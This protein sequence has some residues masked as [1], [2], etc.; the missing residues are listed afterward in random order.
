MAWSIGCVSP[1]VCGAVVAMLLAG[2]ENKA[3]EG[4][5]AS[6][7][8][9]NAIRRQI[10][11]TNP[12]ALVGVVIAI[13]PKGR[14]FAAVSDVPV[15]QFHEGDPMTFIDSNN[16]QLS[17]GIVRRI[18]GNN[19]HVQWYPLRKDQRA[20]RVGDLA[21]RYR[22]STAQPIAPTET[23]TMPPSGATMPP[24][25]TPPPPAQAPVIAPPATSPTTAP[26]Q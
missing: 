7:Q 17:H 13:E 1:V 25:G 12:D 24:S 2:C 21:V 5:P 26:Q 9:V 14:P 16:N 4:A 11:A 10:T 19:V 6:P 20:P 18:V 23:T 15:E 3:R 8:V 22:P